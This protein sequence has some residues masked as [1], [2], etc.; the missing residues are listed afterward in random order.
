MLR[1]HHAVRAMR[2][3]A[4]EPE[5]TPHPWASWLEA[6]AAMHEEAS[7][8]VVGE[9]AVQEAAAEEQEE[10]D[11][12]EAPDEPPPDKRARYEH[13]QP[14]ERA[15]LRS[16]ADAAPMDEDENKEEA[17]D[18]SDASVSAEADSTMPCAP[19]PSRWPSDNAT[20]K[21]QKEP[22]RFVRTDSQCQ[23][24]TSHSDRLM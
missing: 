16:A 2:T 3:V 19:Q 6:V 22:G 18:F 21:Y 10:A 17:S 9:E 5:P 11:G 20:S 1:R 24:H 23:T 8:E 4:S 15:T 13:E 12:A 14:R 7:A